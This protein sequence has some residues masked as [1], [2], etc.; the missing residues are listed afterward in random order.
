MRRWFRST[1]WTRS[2]E[3]A[4]EKEFAERGI[5][6]AAGRKLARFLW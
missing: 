6:A 5:E 1:S 4:C 2:D 3:Q